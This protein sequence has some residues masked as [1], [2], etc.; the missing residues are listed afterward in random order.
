ME[1]I[2]NS[3]FGC[4]SELIK[5]EVGEFKSGVSEV[6]SEVGEVKS[7]VSEVKREVGEAKSEVSAVKSEVSEVKS[8]VSDVN[9][10]DVSEVS[11]PFDV[12]ERRIQIDFA[13]NTMRSSWRM[14]YGMMHA[15]LKPSCNRL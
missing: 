4:F 14:T 2:Q 5:S 15:M 7:E 12:R 3:A 9:S 8:E 1:A 13:Y 6:K 11:R 10:G